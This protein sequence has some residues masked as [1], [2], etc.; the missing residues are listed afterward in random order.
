VATRETRF[1]AVRHKGL[2]PTAHP[3]GLKPRLGDY[4]LVARLSQDALGTVYRAVHTRDSRF[5]RLRVL[6]SPE[7]S[8]GAVLSVIQKRDGP[9]RI[10]SFHPPGR[11]E[12]LGIAE[13]HPYLAWNET[14]GWTLDTIL[15]TARETQATVPIEGALKIAIGASVALEHARTTLIGGEP[16]RHGLLWPGF[17]TVSRN[18]DV[19]VRGFGL[20][21][22]IQPS[23]HQT[24]LERLV[25]PYLAPEARGGTPL[26]NCDVYSIGMLLLELLTGQPPT[27]AGPPAYEPGDPFSDDVARLAL[28]AVAPLSERVASVTSLRERLQR[29]LEDSPYE[30]SNGD[31]AVFLD[32]LLT[33]DGVRARRVRPSVWRPLTSPV[34]GDAAE[35]GASRAVWALRIAAGIVSLAMLAALDLVVHH[36]EPSR[37]PAVLAAAAPENSGRVR[38]AQE[39]PQGE[40]PALAPEVTTAES[41]TDTSARTPAGARRQSSQRTRSAARRA[42]NELAQAWRLRAALCRVSAQTFDAWNLASESFRAGK[43][44][45][46]EGERLLARRLYAAAHEAFERAAEFYAEAEELSHQERARVIRLSSIESRPAA[47]QRF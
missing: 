12:T 41:L 28:S 33:T 43:V 23:L 46:Q 34:G 29:L 17:V 20:A 21:P 13:G 1:D 42:A 31:L 9:H 38:T 25:A 4:V 22:A 15:A 26:E 2:S 40:A 6:E 8:R 27:L 3:G 32:D 24:G 37:V 19:W 47:P 14:S 39:P 44:H 11:R 18:A 10:R 35:R 16:A 5:A 7:L 36:R 45:E 30:R